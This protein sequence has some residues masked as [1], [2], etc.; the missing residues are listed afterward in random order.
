[1]NQDE[2]NSITVPFSYKEYLS[3]LKDFSRHLKSFYLL[4]EFI[5]NKLSDSS[6][7]QYVSVLD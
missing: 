6:I 2:R 7:S 3:T 5:S 1:M 4:L